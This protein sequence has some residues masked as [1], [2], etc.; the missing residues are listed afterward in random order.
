MSN[1]SPS[2]N[3]K[4]FKYAFAFWFRLGYTSLFTKRIEMQRPATNSYFK[5][6][7]YCIWSM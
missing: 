3:C 7:C 5:L 1:I 2:I 6:S 4:D